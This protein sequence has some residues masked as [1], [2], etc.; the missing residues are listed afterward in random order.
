MVTTNLAKLAEELA[1]SA[2]EQDEAILAGD[3]Q[4]S[5]RYGNRLVSRWQRIQRLGDAA[6]EELSKFLDHPNASARLAAAAF[7]LKFKH[8]EA[9][10]VLRDL[11]KGE[12]LV[13]FSAQE[14]I[15][16]W[17]EGTWDLD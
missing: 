1:H 13:S 17:E 2:I 6:K 3:I 8:D 14:C 15:K 4:A 5:R 12:G 16:R 9:M 11:A 10:A 7:L